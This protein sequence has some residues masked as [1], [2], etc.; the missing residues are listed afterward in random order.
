MPARRLAAAAERDARAVGVAPQP[1]HLTTLLHGTML[2]QELH[3][4]T[5]ARCCCRTRRTR[6]GSGTATR[7]PHHLAA[8]HDADT[9]TSCP[10][11]GSLLL[12]NATHALWE[13]HR[14]QDAAR[15]TADAVWIARSAEC[16]RGGRAGAAAGSGLGRR[17]DPGEVGAARAQQ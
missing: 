16:L 17:A 9:G 8:W 6:C 4:R 10:H 2:T 7:T 1:G 12:Q 14:N 13:W 15:V 11:A 5:Q 3:A